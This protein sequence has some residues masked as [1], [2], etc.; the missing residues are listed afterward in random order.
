MAAE[1]EWWKPLESAMTLIT[2]LG[3]PSQMLTATRRSLPSSTLSFS[4]LLLWLSAYEV[5]G[6]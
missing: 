2:M 5:Y 6:K 1:R 4:S 3:G